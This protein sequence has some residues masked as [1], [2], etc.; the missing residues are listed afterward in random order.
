M[1]FNYNLSRNCQKKNTEKNFAFA[2]FGECLLPK[3][4][5][6]TQECTRVLQNYER[7]YV[8]INKHYN[9]K[10][11]INKPIEKIKIFRYKKAELY[12]HPFATWLGTV[13]F[14]K[15]KTFKFLNFLTKTDKKLD[16]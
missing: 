14:R 12:S 2:I 10:Q 13:E 15:N 7:S 16:T 1:Y 11:L 9:I 5:Y 3:M 6:A 4:L 8:N